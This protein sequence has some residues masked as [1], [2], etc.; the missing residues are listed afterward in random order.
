[1]LLWG[2]QYQKEKG[3]ITLKGPAL[4]LNDDFFISNI[5]IRKL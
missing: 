5:K 3:E 4:F 2:L 1:M